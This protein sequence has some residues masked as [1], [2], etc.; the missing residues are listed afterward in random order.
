MLVYPTR[1]Q[2]GDIDFMVHMNNARVLRAS[3][4]ARVGWYTATGMWGAIKAAGG[5][6]TTAAS[7]I[8]YRRSI[9]PFQAFHIRLRLVHWS[10]KNMYLEQ[11]YVH[12]TTGFVFAASYNKQALIGC[13]AHDVRCCAAACCDHWHTWRGRGLE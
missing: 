4:F 10:E 7:T 13:S 12:P 3:D 1:C 2:L 11:L 9:G 6:A 5:S 8:R